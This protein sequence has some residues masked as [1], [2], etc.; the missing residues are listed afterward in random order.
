MF[1]SLF[2]NKQQYGK[3][4]INSFA[5]DGAVFVD[6]TYGFEGGLN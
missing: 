3:I 6:F 1:R 5:I 2:D 4:Y